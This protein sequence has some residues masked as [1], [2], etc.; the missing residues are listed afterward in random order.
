M[1]KCA[2]IGVSGGRA[3]GLAEA[4]QHVTHGKLAAISTRTE[5]NLH[6]FG[7]TFDVDMRYL[8]YR[9]MFEKEQPD[10]VHVNTPP[11][12]RLEIFE[13]AENAGVP[14]VLVEKPIA[15]QGEDWRAIK[16]FAATAKTKIAIN[17]QLHFHPRRQHLQN[18]VQE[19]KIGDVR[20][21]EAS[22][23]MNLAYQGTHAL[24]AIAAFHPDGLPI[25]VMGQASGTD[26]LADT[27]KKHFAPDQCIGA[28]EYADGLRAQLIS[29]PFA[30]RVTNEDRTNVHK[31]IAAYGTRGYVHWTMWSWET[32]IDGHIERGT[33]EY[34]DE[35]ILGQ[36]A[37]TDAMLQWIEDDAKVHPLN[38]DLALRDFNIILGIYTSALEHRPV[39]LPCEPADNLI[40]ALRTRL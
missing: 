17:H 6:T 37:M 28:I 13:A 23:G 3:R 15:I 36:A 9:E 34:P 12:V 33:H 25:K 27:P 29:G 39:E 26:G 7:D 22:C 11:S 4:Y 1:L 19:G 38:L 10:L 20:F 35:D 21:I 18:I 24:Q 5:E 32:G 31:R 30:P 14:A 2:I 16:N 8:D 40:H